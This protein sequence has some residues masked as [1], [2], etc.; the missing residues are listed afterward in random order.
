MIISGTYK[1]ILVS[2]K[3]LDGLNQWT[4]VRVWI[5]PLLFY[6]NNNEKYEICPFNAFLL[7]IA[8]SLFSI[9]MQSR[10]TWMPKMRENFWKSTQWQV[11][12]YC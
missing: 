2:F 8:I 12:S 1:L 10:A 7:I 5:K 9:S 6:V 3:S 4:R 11:K